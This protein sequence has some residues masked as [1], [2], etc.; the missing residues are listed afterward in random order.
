MSRWACSGYRPASQPH[1]FISVLTQAVDPSPRAISALTW[2]KVWKFAW[3]PPN[4]L[5]TASR[6][7]PAFLIASMLSLTTRRFSSVALAF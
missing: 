4:R 3:W 6:K 7:R 5:G 2:R 1:T